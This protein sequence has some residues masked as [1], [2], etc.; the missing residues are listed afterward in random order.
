M[1]SLKVA[2]NTLAAMS[3]AGLKIADVSHNKTLNKMK[4][5]ENLLKPALIIA[6][7]MCCFS[8]S[9]SQTIK[10]DTAK[11]YKMSEYV[12]KP[13]VDTIYS[14]LIYTDC[15]SCQ[16]K[17]MVGYSLQKEHATINYFVN[18]NRFMLNAGYLDKNKKPLNKEIVV[19]ISRVIK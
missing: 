3:R 12:F 8:L 2:Y 6:A 14:Q 13:K 19:I 17:V 10:I 9:Y 4:T 5:L 7:V 11:Y 16:L 18:G 15:D 1:Q